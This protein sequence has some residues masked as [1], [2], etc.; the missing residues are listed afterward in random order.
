M[1]ANIVGNILKSFIGSGVLFLPKAFSN[2]GWIFSTVAMVVMAFFTNVCINKL[3]ACRSAMPSG[4]SYGD[5][6]RRVA[7]RWGGVAVDISLI[8]SQAGFC[9]VY[10][11]FIA[12]NA[13]QLMNTRNCWLHPDY[14]WALILAELPVLAPLTWIRKLSSFG[15]TNLIADALI[16]AGISAILSWSIAGMA[17]APAA[18]HR[19]L[20]DL[21]AMRDATHWPMTLGTAVYAFEGAGM[22]VP[23]VN[24]LPPGARAAFPVYM[25]GTLA[26]VALLYIVIGIVPY[27]FIQ[28]WTDASVADAVTL[29]LPK[30]AWAEL[31][32]AGYCVALALSYPLM[33]FPAMRIIEDAAM[34]Y[35]FPAAARAEAA[36]R[37][38]LAAA[39][40]ARA[41]G[42]ESD[43]ASFAAASDDEEDDDSGKEPDDSDREASGSAID[44]SDSAA[45]LG[46]AAL[47]V[48]GRTDAGVKWKKNIFRAA[49]VAITLLVAYVGASQLDNFVS[50]IG[51]FCCT[52][53][54]FIFPAWFHA[55]LVAGPRGDRSAA[56]ID[57][58][59]VGLGVAIGCFSTYIAV[60]GWSSS[61]FDPCPLV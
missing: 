31:I 21:P 13:M 52:P 22:V 34:P 3:I 41:A 43:G 39:A 48:S 54:A 61:T 37:S 28:G 49:V 35:L 51:A 30:T 9:C 15:P 10:I 4:S 26:G 55:V 2:G 47:T 56:F 36:V 53:I 46:A 59:I 17:G 5:M 19:G 20:V 12:R 60:S 25:A 27:A 23:M 24:A 6:G 58:V 32:V 18:G 7:G 50:L 40:L 42:V 29:N 33:L 16:I 57:W 11:S 45:L 8:L 38:K 44:S 1:R 14:L